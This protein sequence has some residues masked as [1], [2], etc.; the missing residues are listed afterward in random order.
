LAAFVAV[1]AMAAAPAA[2]DFT[3]DLD[4]GVE[5]AF[6]SGASDGRSI[7]LTAEET[8][9][10]EGV[11][12]R[13]DIVADSYDVVIYE[14]QGVTADVGSAL[15]TVTADTGGLGDAYND[16]G[17]DF[18]F[19]AD[20]DYILNFRPSDGNTVWA[21]SFGHYR[22]GD[23][24]EDDVDLDL[25]TIRDGRV[26]FDAQRWQN[27]VVPAMCLYVVPS[28]GALVLLALAGAASPRRRRR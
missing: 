9:T 10:I 11:G 19:E 13:G 24:P 18:T 15:A 17:I 26:G 5:I 21:H 27:T 28:P 14:G 12:L 20:R 22:W 25:V 6:G 4:P 3:L 8:F 7:Y 2:A 23:D 16:I 1:S